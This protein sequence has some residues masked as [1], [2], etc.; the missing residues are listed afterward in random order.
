ML[1]SREATPWSRRKKVRTALRKVH[2]VLAGGIALRD[3]R[4]TKRVISRGAHMEGPLTRD[5]QI[6]RMPFAGTSLDE[7]RAVFADYARHRPAPRL[8]IRQHDVLNQWPRD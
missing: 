1:F 3:T 4:Q 8:A 7:G 5:E 6:E 2:V